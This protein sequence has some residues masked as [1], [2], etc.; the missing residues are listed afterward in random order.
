MAAITRS[1]RG[2][3]RPC[4]STWRQFTDTFLLPSGAVYGRAGQSYILV[5]ENGMTRQIPVAVQVNDG[6]LVKVAA[7]IP[8]GR[9]P[10][11]DA[12]TDGQRGRCA[13]ASAGSGRGAIG[14]AGLREVTAGEV[15]RQERDEDSTSFALA[16]VRMHRP[17]RTGCRS[18]RRAT[19][20]ATALL[21]RG[22]AIT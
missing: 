5:V 13:V 17:D 11:G 8:T 4:G 16:G 7:V 3:P 6:T 1:S 12:R 10:A 2:R 20:R 14:H 22:H 19:A 21:I 9:R 15:V 18:L